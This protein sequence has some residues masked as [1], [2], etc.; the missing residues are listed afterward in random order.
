MKVTGWIGKLSF[1][2]LEDKRYSSP[3]NGNFY[4]PNIYGSRGEEDEWDSYNWPP[5]KVTVTIEKAE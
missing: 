1:R 3:E 4:C 2:R 5:V